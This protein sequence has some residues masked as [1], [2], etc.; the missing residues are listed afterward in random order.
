MASLENNAE[1]IQ[2]NGSG[3]PLHQQEEKNVENVGIP[4]SDFKR[5]GDEESS[6]NGPAAKRARIGDVDDQPFLINEDFEV[7]EIP[8]PAFVGQADAFDYGNN[9]QSKTQS[10]SQIE[11][12]LESEYKADFVD[13]L[14][15]D[16][17]TLI[18]FPKPETKPA[19]TKNHAAQESTGDDDVVVIIDSPVVNH[20][21]PSLVSQTVESI[22]PAQ[23]FAASNQE[24]LNYA[25]A[26]DALGALAD[27]TAI[28]SV[29]SKAPNIVHPNS[30]EKAL[31]ILT[32]VPPA[33]DDYD[34]FK[35]LLFTW[36]TDRSDPTKEAEDEN[37]GEEVAA[38]AAEEEGEEAEPEE[39]L[40]DK[41]FE[42]YLAVVKQLMEQV[43]KS[44]SEMRADTKFA[45]VNEDTQFLKKLADKLHD[46]RI[47]LLSS[48]DEKTLKFSRAVIADELQEEIEQVLDHLDYKKQRDAEA[49]A[50][51]A[52]AVAI[53]ETANKQ[54]AGSSEPAANQS[55][56]E[57]SLIEVNQEQDQEDGVD[58]GGATGDDVHRPNQGSPADNTTTSPRR[59]RETETPHRY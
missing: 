6:Q 32:K 40:A 35:R 58:F 53:S 56:L 44:K 17:I 1:A 50:E 27:C 48:M 22:Q 4:S 30:W 59:E 38:A 54:R 20:V 7:E 33:R 51:A 21:A 46:L 43:E 10:N 15:D 9:G 36:Y 26:K 25:M 24:T 14:G 28:R 16:E 12:Q 52:A 57:I 49:E 47:R 37:P 8:P 41:V 45:A 2:L 11:A 39:D 31:D 29:L 13:L 23:D 5:H 18:Q 3:S 19:Q 34:I 55:D 42:P